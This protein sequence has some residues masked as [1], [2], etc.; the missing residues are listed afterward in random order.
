MRKMMIHPGVYNNGPY[1]RYYLFFSVS[2]TTG[3]LQQAFPET[4]NPFSLYLSFT[5]ALPQQLHQKLLPAIAKTLREN[6][7]QRLLHI[8]TCA[9]YDG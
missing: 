7:G 3:F 5:S 1:K 8:V 6:T 2:R 4:E 9:R